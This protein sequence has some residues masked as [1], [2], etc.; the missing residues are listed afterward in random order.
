MMTVRR[1]ALYHTLA[2]IWMGGTSLARAIDAIC[3]IGSIQFPG[4]NSHVVI[5]FGLRSVWR[6]RQQTSNHHSQRK[7]RKGDHGGRYLLVPVGYLQGAGYK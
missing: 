4:L 5:S 2:R 1:I 6:L 7:A 3:K